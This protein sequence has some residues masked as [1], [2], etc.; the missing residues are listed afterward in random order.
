MNH[1]A[2]SWPPAGRRPI[3]ASIW[4]SRPARELNLPLIVL[5]S[6]PDHRRLKALAGKSVTFLRGKTDEEVA[7]YFQT[8]QAFIFPGA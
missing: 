7:H 5:G 8:S 3:N 6:G 2:G 1:A 4:P